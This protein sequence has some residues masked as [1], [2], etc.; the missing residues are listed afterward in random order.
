MILRYHYQGEQVLVVESDHVPRKYEKVTLCVDGEP[1]GTRPV[2][3]GKVEE[4]INSYWPQGIP[5]VSK[6]GPIDLY[7][8]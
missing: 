4:I 1:G 7:L 5:N 2:I 3:Q 6:P 8:A